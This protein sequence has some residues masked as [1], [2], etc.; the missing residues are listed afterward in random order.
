MN[1]GP[2]A[3]RVYDTL[4][5]AIMERRF[6]PG[7]RLDPAMLAEDLNSSATPVR[8][9]LDRLVGEDLVESRTGSEFF[10]PSLDEPALGDMYGWS[11]ELLG[12]A[13]RAWSAAP[14]VVSSTTALAGASPAARTAELFSAV[15]ARSAN[16]EHRRAIKRLNARLSAVRTI[17][18]LVIE[19]ISRELDELEAC[20]AAGDPRALRR[21]S[22]RFHRRR[23]RAAAAIVRAVYRLD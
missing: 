22:G 16:G 7:D 2:T 18:P 3:E 6:R 9:A 19:D 12:L 14:A 21:A 23:V 10:L 15:A 1:A 17:E 13:V 20:L 5:R 8:E 11:E 4:K